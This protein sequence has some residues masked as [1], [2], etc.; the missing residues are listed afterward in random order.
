MV[1]IRSLAKL[2]LVCVALAWA[3]A[4]VAQP[5]T[6]RF[7]LASDWQSGYVGQIDLTNTGPA[8]I[9]GWT[10]EFDLGGQ[11]VGL[12]NGQPTV[13]GTHY[14]VRDLG[15]NG[16][17]RPGASVGI[18]FQIAYAGARPEPAN[19]RINGVACSLDSAAPASSPPPVAGGAVVSPLHV[20]IVKPIAGATVS[21]VVPV[22]AGISSDDPNTQV[23][24][25][26]FVIDGKVVG[27]GNRTPYRYDWATAS[28]AAGDHTLAARVASTTGSAT[29]AAVTVHVASQSA[30]PPPS[31]GAAGFF[32]MSGATMVDS[33]GAAVRLTGVNWFGFE[34]ANRAVHGLWSRDYRSM[35]RQVRDLGFNAVRIP[36]SNA[37]LEPGSMPTG[38]TF[39][40]SDPYDGHTP[41]NQPLAGK[42]SMEVLDLVI[43]AARHEGLKVILDNHSRKPDD[44]IAEGLWYTTDFPESRWISDWKTM[45]ARYRNEPTVVAF[46]LHNEPHNPATW[47]GPAAT[48]YASAAERAAA[49]IHSV[50]PDVIVIVGGV[51]TYGAYSY[52]WGGNL[53]GVADRPLQIKP[54]KLLYSAHDYGPEVFPQTW[55]SAADYPRNLASLWDQTWGYIPRTGIGGVFIGEFGIGHSDAYSGHA[56]QW[57][58]ALMAYMGANSSW[59]YWSLNPNSGDTGGILQDDWVSVQQWK[60]DLLTPYQARQFP[61]V[62]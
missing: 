23:T 40:G 24:G 37:I 31:A 53:R 10:L 43:A 12:W 1:F 28:V 20:R 50:H 18:G 29:S 26:A 11:L 14:T 5:V 49:A 55:F 62:P 13:A 46:D 59:T 48:D 21:G 34:T 61:P 38:I 52:W 16:E 47:G 9:S 56:L 4:A 8:V 54:G 42:T 36:W 2:S 41:M 58:Q 30:P 45:A 51:Q 39:S 33:S 60:L 6:A 44:F 35:L 57:I 3:H 15:W 25:V 27:P 7:T 19:C 22:V 32:S 17:L